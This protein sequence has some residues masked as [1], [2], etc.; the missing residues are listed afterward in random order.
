MS[1]FTKHVHVVSAD[2]AALRAAAPHVAA[3]AGAEGLA[4]HVDSVLVR[5]GERP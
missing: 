3:L 5:T 2:E 1:D 4:A